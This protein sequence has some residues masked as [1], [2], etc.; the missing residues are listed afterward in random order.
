[1]AWIGLAGLGL[2]GKRLEFTPQSTELSLR[3][4]EKAGGGV[5]VSGWQV[6]VG[7]GK[8]SISKRANP[9]FVPTELQR[10]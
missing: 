3:C 7:W 1:M 5:G 9:P 8:K 4:R 10:Y 2:Q 6:E